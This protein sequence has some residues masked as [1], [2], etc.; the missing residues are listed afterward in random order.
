MVKKWSQPITENS[1]ALRLEDGV[2]TWKDS[3][4]IAK[5]L[6][7]SSIESNVKKSTPFGSAMS[8]LSFYINR[9]GKKIPLTQ[10]KIL[11][12]AKDDLRQLFKKKKVSKRKK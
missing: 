4:K 8:M 10:K 7:Q 6:A 9:A 11:M 3:K 1:R 2:F 12:Q 5:S